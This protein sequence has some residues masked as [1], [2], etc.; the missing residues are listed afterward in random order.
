MDKYLLVSQSHPS[1]L[2]RLNCG[3]EEMNTEWTKNES[4]RLGGGERDER[5]KRTPN[6]IVVEFGCVCVSGRAWWCAVS[7]K[8]HNGWACVCARLC[9]CDFH[10]AKGRYMSI[11]RMAKWDVKPYVIGEREYEWNKGFLEPHVQM[12]QM[13]FC[14]TKIK[15]HDIVMQ[16]LWHQSTW[17]YSFPF[18]NFEWDFFH[19]CN[20]RFHTNSSPNFMLH[21]LMIYSILLARF[22][23]KMMLAMIGYLI[24]HDSSYF[25]IKMNVIGME[26]I[27]CK[28][29]SN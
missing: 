23:T 2:N 21:G 14:F 11:E 9:S 28:V 19:F 29:H 8:W 25:W 17:N 1:E 3:V 13:P 10:I 5:E 7:K 22:I 20:F 6:R 18:T 16:L 24:K 27:G 4:E 15:L 26:M 12:F